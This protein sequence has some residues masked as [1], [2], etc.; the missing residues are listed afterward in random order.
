MSK[1]EKIYSQFKGQ[2]R[3][4][5]GTYYD[6]DGADVGL[7]VVTCSECLFGGGDRCVVYKEKG[8]GD[9]D[10]FR[11]KAKVTEERYCAFFLSDFWNDEDARQEIAKL[12]DRLYAEKQQAHNPTPVLGKNNNPGCIVA[13]FKFLFRSIFFVLKLAFL[14]V[15]VII[16]LRIYYGK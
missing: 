6:P 2:T 8:Y 16:G 7:A 10:I 11:T 1:A 4:E 13:L 14:A 15:I 5:N 12:S 3:F 9:G